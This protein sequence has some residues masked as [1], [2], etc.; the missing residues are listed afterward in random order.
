MLI[1]FTAA[2]VLSSVATAP[3]TSIR[4]SYPAPSPD[5]STIAFQSDR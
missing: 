3:V 4:D 2:V 1:S 5:G